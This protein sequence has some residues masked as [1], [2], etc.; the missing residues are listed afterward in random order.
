M[1]YSKAIHEEIIDEIGTQ[2]LA[3][4][5]LNIFSLN[6]YE[7]YNASVEGSKH[8][9]DAYNRH[10]NNPNY[11]GQT[12][13]DLDVTKRNIESAL[14]NKGDYYSTTD[15][16]GEVNHP[17][18]DVRKIDREGNV[19]ENYQHKVIKDTK[20]L[21][22][23]DNKYLQNDKIIV[24]K[25]GYD[26]H[27][28]E[29][30]NMI[31]NTKDP[32]TK[33]NA[34]DVLDKLERSEISREDANNPRTMAIKMQG[35]QAVGHIAQAGLSD[36]VIVALST[37]ANGAISEIK[38]A[39]ESKDDI[40][41]EKRIKRLLKKV[42][43]SFSKTFKRGSSFG[44]LDAGVGILSQ[45]FKSISS[46]LMSIWKSIRTSMKS[47]FN[48]IYS[49]LSGEIKTYK[50]LVSTITKG[51]LSAIL[52]VGTIALESQ[53]EVFLAPIVTPLV[54]SFLAPALSIVI[55]SIALVIMMKSVDMALNALFGI[56]SKRD[57]SKMKAEEISKICEE[58]MPELIKEKKELKELIS[59]TYKERKL[60]FDKSFSDFKEGLSDNNIDS[61]MSGLIGINSMYDKKLQFATFKEFDS[62]MLSDE[63]F[64]F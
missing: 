59:T 63:S 19:V 12:F 6:T 7:G 16:L 58:L 33:K 51:F 48:A 57:I 24:D 37:L 62:F 23:K 55:G 29:L 3:R 46:K 18:T 10:K 40:S 11:F 45:I 43:E 32:Q 5:G 14:H 9:F 53:L 15:N 47:I 1:A 20:G 31:K 25:E 30:E 36:A 8:T 27:K 64:K 41:I 44:A 52:V 50:E 61:I 38:D 26:K 35:Q 22:G 39:Y 49:F 4:F 60:T 54:A 28:N 56:F 34:Q 17:I 21:F 13:E 42:I 2:T